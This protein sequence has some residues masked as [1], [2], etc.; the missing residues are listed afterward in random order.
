MEFL[1]KNKFPQENNT[2]IVIHTNFK[3]LSTF[4]IQTKALYVVE[5]I[6]FLIA[7]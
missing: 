1:R 6:T 5:F 4:H 7:Q 3:N 2:L